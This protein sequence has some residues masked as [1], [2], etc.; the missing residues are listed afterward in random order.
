M[1]HTSTSYHMAIYQQGELQMNDCL[2]VRLI[3]LDVPI[4]VMDVG[5][6]AIPTVGLKTDCQ[7]LAIPIGT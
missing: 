3:T 7:L 4:V 5:L 6:L 1:R 2:Q